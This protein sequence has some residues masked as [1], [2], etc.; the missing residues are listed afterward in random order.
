MT[1]TDEATEEEWTKA[2]RL[3]R[4]MGFIS[5]PMPDGEVVK[6]D[7]AGVPVSAAVA[8]PPPV[9]PRK[10]EPP[11]LP[12]VPPPVD[13]KARAAGEREEDAGEVPF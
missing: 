10:P 9:S 6:A 5:T 13:Y 11:R 3:W 12:T 7:L 2:R 4:R 1:P 8:S